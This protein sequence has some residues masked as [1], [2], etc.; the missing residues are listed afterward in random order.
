LKN[1][2]SLY[3]DG[4]AALF[5]RRGKFFSRAVIKI[6]LEKIDGFL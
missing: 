4:E 2:F 3:P 1:H 5:L 6:F